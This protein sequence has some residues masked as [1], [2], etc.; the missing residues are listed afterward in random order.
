MWYKFIYV[1]RKLKRINKANKVNMAN[2]LFLFI[3]FMHFYSR[4]QMW[5]IIPRKNE[6]V[7]LFYVNMKF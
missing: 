5:P 6:I 2:I 3:L 4:N 7:D 1:K